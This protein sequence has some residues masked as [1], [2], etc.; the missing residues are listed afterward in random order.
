MTAGGCW[1]DICANRTQLIRVHGQSYSLASTTTFQNPRPSSLISCVHWHR[2]DVTCRSLPSSMVPTFCP[3]ELM[4][5][6]WCSTDSS[7]GTSTNSR[8]SPIV[9]LPN[10]TPQSSTGAVNS[11]TWQG[12]KNV[13]FAKKFPWPLM[14]KFCWTDA[15]LHWSGGSRSNYTYHYNMSMDTNL[16]SGI[17]QARQKKKFESWYIFKG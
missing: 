4:N 9:F 10:R 12:R 11:D 8:I 13:G 1:R 3:G 5:C 14:N 16:D 15:I 2:Y 17:S 7:Q 6:S